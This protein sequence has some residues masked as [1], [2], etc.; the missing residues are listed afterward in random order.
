MSERAAENRKRELEASLRAAR[1]DQE[2]Y[3]SEIA[4]AAS[5]QQPERGFAAADMAASD[6]VLAVL[7][8]ATQPEATRLEVIRRLADSGA[9]RPDIVEALLAIARDRDD[10]LAVRAAALRALG[11]AAFAVV[12]FAP[13]E[14]AYDDALRTI[15]ADPEPSLREAAVVALALR[16]DPEIQQTLLAGLEGRAE[17]PVERERAIQL[18]AEDDHLDNLPWLRELYSSESDAARQEAVRLMSSYTDAAQILEGVLRDKD[19]T[20]AVRQQSAA[21]LRHLAPERFES[22]AKEIVTDSGDDPALRAASLKTLE[23]LGD[24]DRVYR[25]SDFVERVERVTTE[26]SVPDVAEH[27]RSFLARRPVT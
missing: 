18:L 1:A 7:T 8:D 27:A 24:S 25:D 4:D 10:A 17:L 5:A 11:A 12:R 16:H 22:A 3:E 13:H 15:A 21:S 26:E 6:P 19:E 23:H 2:R 20:A 14:Q 9:N